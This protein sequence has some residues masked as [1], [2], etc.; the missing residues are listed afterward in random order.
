MTMEGLFKNPVFLLAIYGTAVFF[1]SF[2]TRKV[3]ETWHPE[4]KKQADAN[5]AKKSY[6]TAGARWWNEVI[7][8]GLGPIFGVLL[9]LGMKDTE[10]FPEELRSSTF[11]VVMAGV[12]LGFTCGYFYKI[13]K[14]ILSRATGVEDLDKAEDIPKPPGA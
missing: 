11:V 1:F 14:K 2:I 10:Y 9:A 3:I 4:F 8:Y 7:L 5:D 6:A 12:C 13:F